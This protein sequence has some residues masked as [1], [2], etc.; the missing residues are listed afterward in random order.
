MR[1][2]PWHMGSH[3]RVL[4]GAALLFVVSSCR[5]AGGPPGGDGTLPVGETS[6][7]RFDPVAPGEACAAGGQRLSVGRDLDGDGKLS[8]E[9]IESSELLC[10]G[11]PGEAASVD[12]MR[13]TPDVLEECGGPGVL[14][15]IGTDS[16]GDLELDDD[17]VK[18][19]GVVCSGT[20]GRSG[21]D[22]LV[23]VVESDSCPHG[24]YEAR[25][26][27]DADGDGSLGEDEILTRHAVCAAPPGAE[28]GPSGAD[29]VDALVRVEDA[30]SACGAGGKRLRLGWD[31][32][33]S[34]ELEEAEVRQQVVLCDAVP[35]EGGAAGP[36]A[37]MSEGSL[38]DPVALLVTAFDDMEQGRGGS[39]AARGTS[40]YSF[41][42]RSDHGDMPYTVAFLDA[43]GPLDVALLEADSDAP[44]SVD[45]LSETLLEVETW[46]C[47]TAPLAPGRD[48]LVIVRELHNI[49][50][51]YLVTVS[52]GAAEGHRFAPR[53]L[54][55]GSLSTGSQSIA[56][57]LS[58]ARASYFQIFPPFEDQLTIELALR[59]APDGDPAPS[60]QLYRGY[61]DEERSV[62]Q[63]IASSCVGPR[64]PA[65]EA[66]IIALSPSTSRGATFDLELSRG[67]GVTPTI[68]LD[69]LVPLAP[70]MQFEPTSTGGYAFYLAG[71]AFYILPD[72]PPVEPIAEWDGSG[73]TGYFELEAGR[74]YYLQPHHFEGGQAL[75]RPSEGN[76]GSPSAPVSLTPGVNAEVSTENAV[77]GNSSSVLGESH[78]IFTPTSGGVHALSFAWLEPT[79]HSLEISLYE[80]AFGGHPRR[81]AETS[82]VSSSARFITEPLEANRPHHLVIR[83]HD[84]LRATLLIEEG[85]GA[86]PPLP[87]DG[88][89]LIGAQIPWHR[90][91]L[92]GPGALLFTASG[93]VTRLRIEIHE[94][95]PAAPASRALQLSEDGSTETPLPA[96]VYYVSFSGGGGP[97]SLWV[98]SEEGAQLV[99]G[100]PPV[101]RSGVAPG[102]RH[103]F[104]VEVSEETPHRLRVNNL[105]G[106]RRNVYHLYDPF[107]VRS[108][109]GGGNSPL[110]TVEVTS[111]AGAPPVTGW[112]FFSYQNDESLL[113]TD[114]EIEVLS[115]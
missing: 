34:G 96:G 93:L 105:A 28:P 51:S 50:N 39:V 113:T 11:Q 89:P 2:K 58:G 49:P 52:P 73:Y 109:S 91:E 111:A 59:D 23:D 6:L 31:L 100:A 86:P 8:D 92:T 68:P 110:F 85:D 60:V 44:V 10:H 12:L 21:G 56:V 115:P 5:P 61:V 95:S 53:V 54:D 74:R 19:R 1:R 7:V 82:N 37:G 26:G 27:Y 4:L 81:L 88:A 20:D 97:Y 71:E 40:V 108:R 43:E 80:D 99:L 57:A 69:T 46:H 14:V 90:V 75:V 3:V 78:F 66:L 41:E 38:E 13:L 62:G 79:R 29:G 42:T 70:L 18:E 67:D 32:D 33:G 35:G 98:A 55:A 24:G 63:C 101:Q 25:A 112:W 17:E 30:G 77:Y 45:C 107:G 83:S 87:L 15:E 16:N 103:W 72:L 76:Q 48:F 104:A 94:G 47:R 84:A 22:A 36:G 102:E 114:F 9:E 106:G 64:V 65:G